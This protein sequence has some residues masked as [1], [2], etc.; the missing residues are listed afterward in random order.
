MYFDKHKASI[1]FD[2]AYQAL[3]VARSK[4]FR[5]VA[6]VLGAGLYYEMKRI[7]S[8]YLS[9]PF[10]IQEDETLFGLPVRLSNEDYTISLEL[11]EFTFNLKKEFI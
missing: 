11:D 2:F 7:N 4:N 10:D 5:P 3:N 6:F 1:A 8:N 9:P